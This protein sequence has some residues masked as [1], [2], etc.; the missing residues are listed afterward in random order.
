MSAGVCG[1][2]ERRARVLSASALVGMSV[3][4]GPWRLSPSPK[5]SGAPDPNRATRATIALSKSDRPDGREPAMPLPPGRRK[6]RKERD[7]CRGGCSAEHRAVSVGTL[8]AS[9]GVGDPVVVELEDVVAAP[10]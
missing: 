7:S 10:G 9:G 1:A 3:P 8:V 6:M 5:L 4:V 2:A